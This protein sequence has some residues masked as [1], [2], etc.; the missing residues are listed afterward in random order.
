MLISVALPVP[1]NRQFDYLPQS[2]NH[3]L[4]AIGSRVRVPFGFQK[5]VGIVVGYVEEEHSQVPANK[6]KAI[7]QII[8]DQPIFNEQMLAFAK[9]LAGYYHF[10]LGE[11]FMVMLPTLIHQGKP[12][13]VFESHWRIAKHADLDTLG[14]SAHRQREQFNLI[15]LNGEHGTTEDILLMEG[16]ERKYLKIL[17]DKGLIEHFTETR[18][19]PKPVKLA[20]LP[21]T[22]N[23]EQSQAVTAIHKAIESQQYQ[24]FLLNGVTGSGKT[25]VYLQ[26]M[27]PVLEAGKQ[28][29]ILVPEI[30]LTPQT[31]ARFSQRFSASILLLHSGLS[32]SSRM[33]GWEDC[34]DGHAQIIIGTRS[35]LLYAFAD[36]GL[37]IVDET[38]D[39]SYKQQDSLRYNAPD[40]A[41]YRGYQSKIPVILGTATPTLEQIKLAEDGK[42]T[43]LILSER[44]GHAKPPIF[45]LVDARHPDNVNLDNVNNVNNANNAHHSNHANRSSIGSNNQ[46]VKTRTTFSTQADGTEQNTG[47]TPEVITAI[48]NTLEAGKQVLIFLNRRGYAPI[49]LCGGCG[50]QA[51]CPNCDSH[52]TVHKFTHPS[53]PL[54]S[55]LSTSQARGTRGYLKCHHCGYQ[56]GIPTTCPDCHSLNL[57][58]VG[59]GTTR[60]TDSLH[61]IFANP[62]TSKKTYPIIQIDRDTTRRKGSWQRIYQQINRGEPSILV[63]TQ[64]IAKGHHFP[65][66]TLVVM[67]NADRGFL[68]SDFR[69]PEHTAQLMIQVAGRAGRA[70]TIDSE[71]GMVLIQTLQPDNPLLLSLVRDGYQRFA[72]QLLK[73]RDMMGLPPY[74]HACLIRC[75]GESLEKTHQ[76]LQDG[77]NMLPQLHPLAN[78]SAHSSTDSLTNS[79]TNNLAVSGVI[80]APM[81]KRNGRYHSQVLIL[82]KQRNHLHQVLNQWWEP[83]Q[84]LPSAKGL[85]LS[86]DIDPVGW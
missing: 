33:Q 30:G 83:M 25:E 51:D 59:M 42:L 44:A 86:L 84:A 54:A 56:A 63:G 27:Q 72:Q 7:K 3:A 47:L 64:M 21:H 48:R 74:V 4:P 36:L 20:K 18:K 24:G 79:L 43:Q 53:P 12:L 81:A 13:D 62:Q 17:A 8:D 75:E 69:S 32:D 39:Q 26:A 46:P 78:Q 38:H 15:K 61:S 76:A 10:P 45:K 11:V 9:W 77:I 29:L 50:W 58:P 49:L 1:L 31:K 6:L 85:K 68:S 52:L 67:P 41:L 66:V 80:D 37:I 23:H 35:A 82:A 70:T 14:K 40:V 57:D 71:A 5:L 28:V 65:Q 55:S 34:K 16:V 60:L 19:L 73:E 2:R 22:L